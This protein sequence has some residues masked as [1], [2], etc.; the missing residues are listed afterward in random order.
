MKPEINR[1]SSLST[2]QPEWQY[3]RVNLDPD[4]AVQLDTTPHRRVV[5]FEKPTTEFLSDLATVCL[6]E[7]ARREEAEKRE[8]S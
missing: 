8:A 6:G 2:T 4:D 5:D 7:I 1:V 3:L